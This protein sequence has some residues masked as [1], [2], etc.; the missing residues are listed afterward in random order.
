MGGHSSPDSG[1]KDA[2]RHVRRSLTAKAKSLDDLN[3]QAVALRAK[4]IDQFTASAKHNAA[5]AADAKILAST[6][7]SWSGKEKFREAPEAKAWIQLRKIYNMNSFKLSEAEANNQIGNINSVAA[8]QYGAQ[9]NL[10]TAIGDTLQKAGVILPATL[11]AD[12]RK[13]KGSRRRRQSLHLR[14]RNIFP[15]SILSARRPKIYK[16]LLASP[17]C[18]AY[19]ANTSTATPPN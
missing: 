15:A 12:C 19:T 11:A 16:K 4:A 9:Q 2:G 13:D 10:A 14:R 6:L 1:A 17:A 3:K 5:A 8:A 7:D 18:S